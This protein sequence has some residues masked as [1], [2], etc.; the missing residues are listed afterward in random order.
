MNNDASDKATRGLIP[1]IFDY[2]FS[3]IQ[4]EQ[5]RVWLKCV[6]VSCNSDR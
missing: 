6:H 1:R 4:R 2:M 3:L 5:Q